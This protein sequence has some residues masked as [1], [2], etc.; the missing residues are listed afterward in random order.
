LDAASVQRAYGRGRHAQEVIDFLLAHSRAPLPPSVEFTLRD[1]ERVHRKVT[2]YAH[3][4]LLH[5]PDPDRLD[6]L[7]A[8]LAHARADLAPPAR[9]SATDAF[10]PN[11]PPDLA[12][13][14]A[15]GPVKVF[16]LADA[17]VHAGDPCLRHTGD[18][19][20]EPAPGGLDLVTAALLPSLARPTGDG[21]WRLDGALARANIETQVLKKVEEFFARARR[22]RP[23]ARAAAAPGRAGG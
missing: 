12:R 10:L 22:G 8:A 21:A 3:G 14:G 13:H 4:A 9:L 20:L 18:L 23:L 6:L 15:M 16:D 5:Q 19:R 1:W 17:P 2:L 11:L 7:L